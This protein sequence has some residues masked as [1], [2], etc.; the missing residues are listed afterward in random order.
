MN[1]SMFPSIPELFRL[2]RILFRLMV[3]VRGI[4][5]LLHVD[6]LGFRRY[7]NFSSVGT[8]AEESLTSCKMRPDQNLQ[9]G[10]DF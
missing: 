8:K 10:T 7:D 2:L 9:T 1:V 5:Q 3:S 6:D 4:I